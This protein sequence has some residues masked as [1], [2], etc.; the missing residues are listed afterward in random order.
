[1]SRIRLSVLATIRLLIFATLLP[2]TMLAAEPASTSVEAA[3]YQQVAAPGTLMSAFGTGFPAGDGI[4]ESATALPLPV[5][6]GGVQVLIDSVPAPL[7]YVGVSPEGNFQINYQL[8]WDA[9]ESATVEVSLDDTVITT[10]SLTIGPVAPGL[11]SADGTG[12]G[13]IAAQN[14][15]GIGTVT[16]NNPANPIVQGGILTLYGTGTGATV[17]QNTGLPGTPATGEG[18]PGAPLYVTST[19]PSITVGG[20]PATVL[21][22]GLTPGLVGVWQINLQLDPATPTGDSVP[23]VIT[24]GDLSIR[25]GVTVAVKAASN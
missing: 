1:M 3:G 14:F 17:D 23:V 10:E 7:L 22:S 2:L 13:Q 9:A 16:V 12:L 11:F 25:E 4:E 19:L 21:F 18:A 15:E 24:Y 8:P 5:I 6:L 20:L